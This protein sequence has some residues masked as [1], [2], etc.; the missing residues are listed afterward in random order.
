MLKETPTFFSYSRNDSEF[1]LRLARDLRSLRASVWLDQ[2]DISAG[3]RWD[4]AVEQALAAA[5]RVIVILSPAAVASANVMDEVSFALEE[6]KTVIPVLYQECKIP[7]RLRRFQYID[8]RANYEDS[9]LQLQK[10]LGVEAPQ[11]TSEELVAHNKLT[12]RAVV[13]PTSGPIESELLPLAIQ[14][15]EPREE[16]PG[17]RIAS[18]FTQV[19]SMLRRGWAY[20]LLI[21]IV[22]VI[23]VVNS[24]RNWI[25]QPKTAN[26]S[27]TAIPQPQMSTARP[28]S[29]IPGRL[30]AA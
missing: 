17:E 26:N 15:P 6:N 12:S 18:T 29:S 2:L 25:W 21:L 24:F 3:E 9:A 23:L 27:D 22:A 4:H 14:A 30:P 7:L 16:Q 1:A 11:S 13:R 19:I 5:Q 20:T 8:F 10:A 28:S